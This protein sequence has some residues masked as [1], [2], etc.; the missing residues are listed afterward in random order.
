MKVE[1]AEAQGQLVLLGDVVV[2]VEGLVEAQCEALGQT[3]A[4]EE[5]V[6]DAD[7]LGERL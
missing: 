7:R 6:A 3:L 4:V 2:D 1:E 5:G